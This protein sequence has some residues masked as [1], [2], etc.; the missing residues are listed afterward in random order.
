MPIKTTKKT[1]KPRLNKKTTKKNNMKQNIK[2]NISTSGGSGGGGTSVPNI[3]QPLQSFARSEKIG[4]NVNVTNLLNR[5]G[6]QQAEAFNNFSNI[7]NN[8]M[9][10]RNQENEMLQQ[11]NRDDKIDI[12]EQVN[13]GINDNEIFGTSISIPANSTFLERKEDKNNKSLTEL[14][15][16]LTEL[17]NVDKDKDEDEDE[18]AT[19]L[20]PPPL[21]PISQYQNIEIDPIEPMTYITQKGQNFVFK[22]RTAPQ[23]TKPTLAEAQM[24][25]AIFISNNNIKFKDKKN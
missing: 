5:I 13:D 7:I 1:R 4:E 17:K 16:P 20:S 3:P 9:R 24:E 11:I 10:Q 2:I 22:F 23:I 19:R 6:S 21:P 12:A 15:Q 25:R 18:R 8:S 14:V